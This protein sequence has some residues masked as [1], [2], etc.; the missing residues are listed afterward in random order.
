MFSSPLSTTQA[1][2]VLA[3]LPTLAASAL[4]ITLPAPE[5]VALGGGVVGGLY[6]PAIQSERASLALFLMHSGS[7]YLRWTPC[8]ELASRGYAIFC[9]N[10]FA[11]KAGQGS[12]LDFD[13]MMQNVGLG[14]SY[15][16]NQTEINH[17][18]LLG[19]SGG[20]AMMA[21]YQNIA[22]NGLSACNGAEK[23]SPCSD[24][25]VGMQPADGLVLLDANY[26]TSTMTLLSVNPAVEDETMG[27]SIN[28]SLDLFNPANGFSETGANYSVAFA[29]D[30]QSGVAARWQRLLKYAQERRE[31]IA[32]GNGTFSNDEPFHIP[33]ANFLGGNNKLFAQD[34]KFLSHTVRQWP[35]LHKNGSS[36][37]QI[38]RSV[39]VPA[40]LES[41]TNSFQQGALKTTI[42]RFLRTFAIRVSEDFG[43][44]ADS[45]T[46]IDW[47]SSHLATQSSVSGIRVP[48]LTM[49]DDVMTKI[50]FETVKILAEDGATNGPD[51]AQ[52][53][54]PASA[55]KCQFTYW[56][57]PPPSGCDW[58]A[59]G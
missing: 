28:E 7:D 46:G 23:I 44:T 10:N 52:L 47:T 11:S 30:F 2:H 5:L 17:I 34:T 39:R 31:I 42:N 6:R 59:F 26:G 9:A 12:D 55:C 56:S 22:E 35:L 36:T 3:L 53:Y 57:K 20:G 8:T 1:L 49:E 13:L 18:V 16:R 32:A 21:A 38:V 4:N 54:V 43:F 50:S 37:T 40:N 19:H 51:D 41:H 33:D 27:A 29:K 24:N 48:I 58:G 25:L 45:F 15:L 14:M